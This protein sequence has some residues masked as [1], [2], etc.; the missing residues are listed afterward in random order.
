MMFNG[1]K[2]EGLLSYINSMSSK[3]LHIEKAEGS[4]CFFSRDEGARYLYATSNRSDGGIYETLNSEW[5]Y[6]FTFK[7]VRFYRKQ[8][9]SELSTEKKSFIREK[10]SDKAE[11]EWLKSKRAEGER[12]VAFTAGEYVFDDSIEYGFETEPG[13]YKVFSV[14]RELT[15][16]ENKKLI[17]LTKHGWKFLFA[18]DNGRRYYF[19]RAESETPGSRGT[20]TEVATAFLGATFSLIFMFASLG[21]IVFSVIRSMFFNGAFDPKRIVTDG[22]RPEWLFIIGVIGTFIFGIAYMIFSAI[23]SKRLEARRKRGARLLRIAEMTAERNTPDQES[24]HTQE[25]T[26]LYTEPQTDENAAPDM[27][28]FSVKGAE[29]G[30]DIGITGFIFNVL[31]IVIS[32]AVFAACVIFCYVYFTVGTANSRWILIPAFLGICFFPFVV[33]GSAEKCAAFISAR[34]K[35]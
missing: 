20:V 28:A 15:E 8:L 33:Y 23:F 18:S 12:L 34:R 1:K 3:G 22:V 14:S 17:D 2:T 6:V 21:G 35:K 11:S 24:P 31:A 29:Y 13:E 9:P 5:R 25:N 27:G 26:T 7:D 10:N 16:N 30:N 19:F 4:T 32:C